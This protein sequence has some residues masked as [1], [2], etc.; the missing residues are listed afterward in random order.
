MDQDSL[1]L[2]LKNIK[3]VC[4]WQHTTFCKHEVI[5]SLMHIAVKYE[6]ADLLAL[7]HYHSDSPVYEETCMSIINHVFLMGNVNHRAQGRLRL[8][9]HFRLSLENNCIFRENAFKYLLKLA[10]LSA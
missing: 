2:D 7:W 9:C 3:T 10:F 8:L 6:P 4:R 5:T 1:A